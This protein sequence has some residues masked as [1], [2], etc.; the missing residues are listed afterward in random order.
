MT[1]LWSIPLLI[2]C[3][4]LLSKIVDD[5]FIDSLDNI[6]DWLGLSPSV[7]GATLLAVGT[8]A[9]EL[10]TALFALFLPNS[11]PAIGLGTVVG[12]AIFQVLVVIGF[13]AL[14]RTS[15]LN[16][17]PV[18]RDGV[19]YAATIIL[20]ILFVGDGSFTLL[21]SSLL[22]LTY[23]LYLVILFIWTKYIPDTQTEPDPID[24]VSESHKKAKYPIINL[25]TQPL[26]GIMDWILPDCRVDQKQTLRVFFTSLILIAFLSYWLVVAAQSISIFIGIPPAIVALTILAGGSSIPELISSYVVSKEGRGDMAIAN[27]IGSNIFDIL[28]SLG[29]PLFI[30]TAQ[31]GTL[32]PVDSENITSSILLLFAT[33]I[34]LFAILIAQKFKIGRNVGL[35]LIALYIAY[36][37][38]AYTGML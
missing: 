36:V 28:I 2:F 10:S 24:I 9:P 5:Y 23:V 17:K 37:C 25:M 12:S 6:S 30:Y 32:S 15:Y 27:A 29:L 16:W 19:F 11:N 8:S 34:A 13:A 21:E 20:L 3:F 38:A 35:V 26:D 33:L 31:F 4:Y 18:M 22:L 7:A 14:V 1:L